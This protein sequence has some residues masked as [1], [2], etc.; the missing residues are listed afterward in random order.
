MTDQS[1]RDTRDRIIKLESDVIHIVEDLKAIRDDVHILRQSA[2][3]WKGATF[4]LLGAGSVIGW[5]TAQWSLIKDVF[6][7]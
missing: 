5:V 6:V 2:D 4:V 1:E 7:R 3:R